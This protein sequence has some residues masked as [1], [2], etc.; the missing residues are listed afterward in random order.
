MPARLRAEVSRMSAA[1]NSVGYV[2]SVES[3]DA[4]RQRVG[5]NG[6]RPQ[7]PVPHDRQGSDVSALQNLSPGD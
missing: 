2:Q 5:L 3:T 4:W 6:D 1:K 7:L